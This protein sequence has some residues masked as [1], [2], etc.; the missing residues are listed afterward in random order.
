M[1]IDKLFL[2]ILKSAHE[3]LISIDW[4]VNNG[5]TNISTEPDLAFGEEFPFGFPE[6]VKRTPTS[7][8]WNRLSIFD[9]Y[10]NATSA[11]QWQ[12]NLG[13]KW[14]EGPLPSPSRRYVNWT[15]LSG[16][17]VLPPHNFENASTVPHSCMFR[18]TSDAR[19]ILQSYS[20]ILQS[21]STILRYQGWGGAGGAG[22][23]GGEM[24]EGWRRRMEEGGWTGGRRGEEG[25][26]TW[27][28]SLTNLD[29]AHPVTSKMAL[30]ALLCR[31]GK[32]P[33]LCRPS[34]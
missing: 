10:Q 27:S 18:R 22:G 31:E 13:A 4:E 15:T 30:G 16:L 3:A 8:D 29:A 17:T 6:C 5:T 24:E 32:I 28:S 9:A 12:L 34:G 7:T 19:L 23:R 20:T 1:G 26:G 33:R 14:W 2:C 25:W 21:Y 11:L